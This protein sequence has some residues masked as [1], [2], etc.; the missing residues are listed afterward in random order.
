MKKLLLI[1]LLLLTF[2]AC[3]KTAEPASTPTPTPEATPSATTQT[4]NTV[5]PTPS[6]TQKPK[7]KF[8]DEAIDQARAYMAPAKLGI[9]Y[10]GTLYGSQE[11]IDQK[12]ET[13]TEHYPFLM[14][15][16]A[17]QIVYGDIRE[18]ELYMMLILI[19]EDNATL[20]INSLKDGSVLYRDEYGT[21]VIFVD[22]IV[23]GDPTAEI[24]VVAENTEPASIQP[25]LGLIDGHLRE[26]MNMLILDLSDYDWLSEQ[27][28]I[29]FYQQ[30][31]F[32]K[33]MY[34]DDVYPKVEAG[35]QIRAM[36]DMQ[37]DGHYYLCFALG[38]DPTDSSKID[39]FYCT[40]PDSDAVY[41]SENLTDWTK[42]N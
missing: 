24:T 4:N 22:T 33:I 14:N 35:K 21:P 9:I 6:P 39:S 42:L 18:G 38:D 31:C 32:D 36:W 5:K 19:P 15:M 16:E 26:N 23:A 34:R 27:S 41:Y 25:A 29:P 1:L 2:T 20:S 8:A 3:T 30:S 37:I 40:R 28:D 12:F 10:A 11:E 13:I 17:D 7:E